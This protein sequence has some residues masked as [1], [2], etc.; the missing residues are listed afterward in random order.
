[1]N[2]KFQFLYLLLIIYP[3][4]N[5]SI[6]EPVLPRWSTPFIIP[7]ME[8]KL[9]FS[10]EISDDSSIVVKGDSLYLELRGDFDPHSITSEDLSIDAYDTSSSFA[11]DEIKISTLGPLTTGQVNATEILPYLNGLIDQTVVVPETT[12]TSSNTIVESLD[13]VSMRVNEGTLELT[14]YNNLP[15]TLAPASPSENSVEVDVYNDSNNE[16]ITTITI[17]DTIFPGGVGR[18]STPLGN[19][20]VW[21][22]MP[23]RLDY[24]FHIL[25]ETIFVTQQ[26]LENWYFQID[27]L[28]RDLEVDQIEGMVPSQTFDDMIRVA[29]DDENKLIEAEI[30]QGSITITFINTLP[31]PAQVSYTL[32]DVVDASFQ[33]FK[34]SLRVVQDTTI[35]KAFDGYRIINSQNP[36]EVI[37]SLSIMTH[38][39]T[40]SGLIFIKASDEIEVSVHLSETFLSGLKGYLARDTLEL[41]PVEENDIFDYDGFSGGVIIE[42]AQLLLEINNGIN[43]DSLFLN[44]QITGY[45]TNQ[46]GQIIDSAEVAINDERIYYGLNTILLEGS[47]VDGLVN[48][49][50][51]DFKALGTVTYSGFAEVASGDII[52]GGYL[53]TTPFRVHIVDPDP[54]ELDP[55]TLENDENIQDSAG[56]DIQ[57]AVFIT[58]LLNHSPLGG[59]VHLFVSADF[60]REDLYDTTGYFNPELEFIKTID[61]EE[62]LVDPATGFVTQPVE[63]EV[64]LTLSKDELKIFQEPFLRTGAVFYLAETDDFVVLR[65]S[66]YL[67][68]SGLVKMKILF[69]DE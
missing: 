6:D 50:P 45:H 38:A 64:I 17:A 69:K 26:S 28:F 24:Q 66:D 41:D 60:T 29:A 20:Q 21:I 52:E 30:E 22:E 19:G 35:Q 58:N 15:F 55:D 5:C 47:E 10:E 44:G 31:L 23:L 7:I 59:E 3:L 32:L 42:G 68:I 46:Q 8:K 36:G 1:M 67:Q 57:S 16:Y 4:L 9:I 63:S 11:L 49:Y 62:G 61:V 56:E 54:I 13:L 48:I 14:I 53:F 43:I 65:G 37:D 25:E 51:T 12:V 18:G 2:R 39:R 27:L 40:D 33:P 34:D